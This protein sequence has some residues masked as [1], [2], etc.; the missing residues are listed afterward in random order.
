LLTQWAVFSS[1]GALFFIIAPRLGP[2]GHP[3][4]IAM[5]IL[6]PAVVFGAVAIVRFYCGRR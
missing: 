1:A 6:F 2:G 5:A 4:P 3:Q